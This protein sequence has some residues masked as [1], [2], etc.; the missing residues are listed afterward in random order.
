MRPSFIEVNLN[1]LRYNLE[2]I[3]KHTHN[4]PIMAVV[5]SNAYGHGLLEVSKFLEKQGVNS[6]GVALLEEGICLR[7]NGIN[8]PIVV[9]GEAIQD[10]IPQY[11]NWNLEFFVSSTDILRI[12]EKICKE[13][14]QNAKVHLKFDS[15]MGRIGTLTSNSERF[16]E[17]AVRLKHIKIKGVCSHLA[18][19]DDPENTLT[20]EQVDRFLSAVEI[21]ESLGVEMPL[22]R[23]PLLQKQIVNKCLQHKKPVIIATQML[24]SMTTNLTPTRAIGL[25]CFKS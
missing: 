19:A 15:G 16:I 18:C 8:L 24:D 13:S 2:S 7:E 22:N 9:F 12:T 10:Q 21:F 17:E 4:R 23:L 5:K 3:R 14:A 25:T 20:N 6:L 1:N 11:L